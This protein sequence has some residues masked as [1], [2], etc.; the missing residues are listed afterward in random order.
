[1]LPAVEMAACQHAQG[2]ARRGVRTF[3]LGRRRNVRA[4]AW[5]TCTLRPNVTEFAA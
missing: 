2:E 5:I 3:D 4:V 1:M